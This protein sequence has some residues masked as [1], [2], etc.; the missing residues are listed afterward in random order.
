MAVL[1]G[2]VVYGLVLVFGLVAGVLIGD[3][4]YPLGSRS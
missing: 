4:P 1:I 2:S 3:W